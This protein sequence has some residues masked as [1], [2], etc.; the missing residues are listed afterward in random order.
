MSIYQHLPLK[1][2]A[3]AATCKQY[4]QGT[5]N[6]TSQEYL[7]ANHTS[8]SRVTWLST[9]HGYVN[10][11]LTLRVEV[12]WNYSGNEVEVEWKWASKVELEWK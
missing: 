9:M 3:Q 6:H 1:Q 8:L 12:E 10:D 2:V 11:V 4:L 5:A 7:H